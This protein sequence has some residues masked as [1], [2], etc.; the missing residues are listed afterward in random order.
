MNKYIQHMAAAGLITLALTTDAL[1]YKLGREYHLRQ[2]D[3]SVVEYLCK[4]KTCS[5]D[6]HLKLENKDFGLEAV[7]SHYDGTMERYRISK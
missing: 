2:V 1:F 7:I 4:D 6:F 5:D 3:M